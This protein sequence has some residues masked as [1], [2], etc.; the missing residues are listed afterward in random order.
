MVTCS[1]GLEQAVVALHLASASDL[2]LEAMSPQQLARLVSSG[3]VSTAYQALCFGCMLLIIVTSITMQVKL[4]SSGSLFA[5]CVRPYVGDIRRIVRLARVVWLGIQTE[6]RRSAGTQAI[7]AVP[8]I[9][10]CVR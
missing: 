10:G 6:N 8:T 4:V 2:K 1:H 3:S 7:I 9:C 5:E